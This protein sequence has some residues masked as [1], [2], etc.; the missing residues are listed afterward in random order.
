MPNADGTSDHH[1]HHHDRD[2]DPDKYESENSSTEGGK[3]YQV[4]VPNYLYGKTDQLKSYFRLG[5]PDPNAAG[6]TRDQSTGA[7]MWE[8]G[9]AD[10]GDDLLNNV[11]VP[12]GFT[13]QHGG[14]RDHTDGNRIVTTRQ[15]VVEVIGGQY[16]Q[17]VLSNQRW[18][19]S[20]PDWQAPDSKNDEDP[21]ITSH[22]YTNW[23]YE[24]IS[25]TTQ[26]GDGSFAEK[27]T[28]VADAQ[29]A[30]YDFYEYT[31]ANNLVEIMAGQ[32]SLADKMYAGKLL[33]VVSTVHQDHADWEVG[34]DSLSSGDIQE[35]TLGQNVTE[36]V[37]AVHNINERTESHLGGIDSLTLAAGGINEITTAAGAIHEM[38][39]AGG[40]IS[41]ETIAGGIVHEL[42]AAAG[43]IMEETVAGGLILELTAAGGN[44]NEYAF[45]GGVFTD[46][47]AGGAAFIEIMSAGQILLELTTAPVVI[48][49][50]T[51]TTHVE[52]SMCE[53]SVEFNPEPKTKIHAHSLT[54]LNTELTKVLGSST[55]LHAAET[56]IAGAVNHLLEEYMIL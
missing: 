34:L 35:Y 51:A 16:R 15:D 22:E 36:V 8:K 3:Y 46:I 18:E 49:I 45:A 53:T 25:T 26:P 5:A 32:T 33:E 7:M 41:E 24:V 12:D 48:E 21:S 39:T 55:A 30:G 31:N 52:V 54:E 14:V 56:K 10:L 20:D 4:W 44:L 50:G 43:L 40:G 38:T 1:H 19:E 42:T 37:K 13:A 17:L 6:L 9:T 28:K 11:D 47:M 27:R 23:Y 29:T 2:P